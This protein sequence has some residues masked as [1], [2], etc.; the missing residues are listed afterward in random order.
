[1]HTVQMVHWQNSTGTLNV[2]KSATNLP[3]S[4]LREQVRHLRISVTFKTRKSS[5]VALLKTTHQSPISILSNAEVHPDEPKNTSA[6]GSPVI[7]LAA[8]EN[9]GASEAVQM[10]EKLRDH[11]DQEPGSGHFNH[12]VV[13]S[14]PQLGGAGVNQ[15]SKVENEYNFESEEDQD[16]SDASEVSESESLSA[17]M[18]DSGEHD[19]F[20]IEFEL[21]SDVYNIF[22]L[23]NLSDEELSDVDQ[24]STQEVGSDV[25][26]LVDGL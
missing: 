21:G 18:D 6:P 23:A 4:L 22:G 20:D 12:L 2:Y 7:V 24:G 13:P 9:S 17:S 14:G 19:E 16:D 5:L 11:S 25:D 3:Q 8:S 1:L 15:E 26:S 10:P